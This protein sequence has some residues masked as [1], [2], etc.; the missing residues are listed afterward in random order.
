MIEWNKN[1]RYSDS[2]DV[3]VKELL[4]KK[5]QMVVFWWVSFARSI[6]MMPKGQF[7]TNE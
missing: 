5:K 6:D 7:I 2:V 1:K 3:K 4:E